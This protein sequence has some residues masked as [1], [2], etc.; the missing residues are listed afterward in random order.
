MKRK[1]FLLKTVLGTGGILAA[2]LYGFAEPRHAL[3][4]PLPR[5]KVK[6]L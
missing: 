3:L 6:S 5:E 4:D 1:D 2:P